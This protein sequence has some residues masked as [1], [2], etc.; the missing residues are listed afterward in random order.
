MYEKYKLCDFICIIGFGFN[1]DDEHINGIIRTLIDVDDK[2]IIVIYI[3]NVNDVDKIAK[4][5]KK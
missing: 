1:L 3:N 2:H 5:L 4:K